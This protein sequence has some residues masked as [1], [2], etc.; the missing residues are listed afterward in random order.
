MAKAFKARC[1]MM[2]IKVIPFQ[3]IF[4]ID[5]YL[6]RTDLCAEMYNNSPNCYAA[7]NSREKGYCSRRSR[8]WLNRTD[9]TGR[10]RLQQE[11]S[12]RIKGPDVVTP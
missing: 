12:T 7:G 5:F 6:K 10:R 11:M 3:S 8:K 9:I 2:N 4:L 1:P